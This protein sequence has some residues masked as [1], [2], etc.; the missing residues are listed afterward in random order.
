MC[1]S[2]R[3][4][5]SARQRGSVRRSR[6]GLASL[7]RADGLRVIVS[8]QWYG[9]PLGA[10]HHLRYGICVVARIKLRQDLARL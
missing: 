8:L 1:G 6:L 7:L 2:V 3:Q 4:R 10:S 9:A 5:G